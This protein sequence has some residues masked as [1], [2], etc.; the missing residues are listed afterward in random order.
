MRT[1]RLYRSTRESR[2]AGVCGGIAEHLDVDPV[3]V[4]LGVVAITLAV[5]PLGLLSYAVA[6]LVMPTGP[7]AATEPSS[8]PEPAPPPPDTPAEAPAAAT[9]AGFGPPPA[10][11]PPLSAPA[12][13]GPPPRPGIP[14]QRPRGPAFGGMVLILIGLILLMLN[15]GLFEWGIFRLVRWR[16]L[17]PTAMIV[18]GVWL[19][20]RA[21]QPASAR[22]ERDHGR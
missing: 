7:P 2:I 1:R 9:P 14:G 18:L 22:M 15:L 5:P 19:L 12:D 16:Y 17:W 6:W 3:L 8:S 13:P 4:R 10:E 21:V 11:P 20:V